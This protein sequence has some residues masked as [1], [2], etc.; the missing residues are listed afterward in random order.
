M[1]TSMHDT[2]VPPPGSP[3]RCIRLRRP[4]T[5]SVLD[6][7]F[8]PDAPPEKLADVEWRWDALR[9]ENPNYYDGRLYHVLGVSRNGYGG[10]VLHVADCAYRYHAVQNEDFDLGVRPLG[11]K[12]IVIR[13]DRVLLG[14]R[15]PNVGAYRNMW[16]FAPA[17][18][19]D[20]GDTP[21]QAILTELHE[22][23][24]LT[25]AY[26]PTHIAVLYDPVLRC[27]EVALRIEPA[28][29]GDPPTKEYAAMQWCSLDDLPAPLTPIATQM[30]PLVRELLV[31]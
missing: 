14:Q 19:V 18:V 28:A 31:V 10:A 26:E 7:P 20:P 21:S 5:L 16:E 9:E 12:G 3:A 15:A 25:A 22:E 2:D 27:W 29:G 24:G 8:V 23:T 1:I 4:A 17:G 6:E 11:V 13:D 30:Q